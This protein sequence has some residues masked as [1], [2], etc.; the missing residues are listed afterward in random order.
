MLGV[1][2]RLPLRAA[3]R[4]QEYALTQPMY[5]ITNG[6]ATGRVRQFLDFALSPA[7]Q[8]IVSRYAAPIR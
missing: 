5:L 4:S 1:E 8:A 6:Q 3:L 7:G 2:G